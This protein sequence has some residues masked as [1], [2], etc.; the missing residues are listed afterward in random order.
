MNETLTLLP[1]SNPFAASMRHQRPRDVPNEPAAVKASRNPF[2]VIIFDCDE[3]GAWRSE[4]ILRK[5]HLPIG[6]NYP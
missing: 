3:T 4:A 1:L 2:W 5:T 6:R